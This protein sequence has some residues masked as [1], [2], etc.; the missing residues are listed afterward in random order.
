MGSSKIL[1]VEDHPA[2]LKMLVKMLG[3]KYVVFP[4]ASGQEAVCIARDEK[5]D[6]VLLDIEMPGMDGF[7]TFDILKNEIIEQAVPVI[8]LTAREDSQSREK[9]LAA[10][11]VDYITKPY[12]S[13]EL[14][15]KVKNHLA[16]Y[17]ARKEIEARNLIM[18][19]EMEMASQ[20]QNSL[21]PHDFPPNNTVNFSAVYR[22]VS[23]AGGDFYDVIELPD[24]RIG[25][26][27]V[28][29]SGHGVSAAMIGA[30]FKM[31][32]QSFARVTPSPAKLLSLLNDS[33]FQILPES[34]FLT[35]FY[36]IIDTR[37]RTLVFTNAGHPM[38]FLY[39][40]ST[41]SI[42]ELSA[43]GPLVGA[44]PNMDYDEMSLQLTWGDRILVFT[45]GVTEAE[46]VSSDDIFYGENRLRQVFLASCSRESSEILP[47]IMDDLEEFRSDPTFRD[48]VSMMLVS[49]T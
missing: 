2:S 3:K 33:L 45:D 32:F 36:G 43:G 24:C 30:M 4:A 13:Q 15:I 7:Q 8:F 21:L 42:E 26:A 9:G 37:S 38:P 48:D 35:V 22:P 1:V 47:A 25:F 23:T 19:K 27:Q 14:A 28:D 5:P 6:L 34:D 40:R 41:G 44:F 18:A 12:D 46:K 49:V 20:L 31:A 10:G 16:L 39:R 29:V 11:A 17:E